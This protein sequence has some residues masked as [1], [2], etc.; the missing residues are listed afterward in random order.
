VLAPWPDEQIEADPSDIDEVSLDLLV[1]SHVA[2][3]LARDAITVAYQPVVDARSGGIRS[4]E[5]LVRCWHPVLGDL[6]SE[7]IVA[8]AEGQ[9]VG[10]DLFRTVLRRSLRAVHG[11]R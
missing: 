4:V 3:A 5:A 10:L 7:R 9:G 2:W 6:P 1:A 8:S 11:L